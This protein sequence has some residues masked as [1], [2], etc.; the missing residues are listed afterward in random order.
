[1]K[2]FLKTARKAAVLAAFGIFVSC[3]DGIDDMIDNYNDLF[4]KPTAEETKD[5]RIPGPGDDDFVEEEMLG[6]YYALD[7]REKLYLAGP[8][9]AST[10]VWAIEPILTN[11]DDDYIGR[12]VEYTKYEIANSRYYT[13]TFAS[14]SIFERGKS[15][16][17]S[18]TVTDNLGKTYSDE[19]VL[20]ITA[21]Y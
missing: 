8:P 17:L 12:D 10:Y 20:T 18:L 19:A 11:A 3:S 6:L 5:D 13:M 15:Y 9:R 16:K 14:C 4:A 2:A 21:I 7:Y 1:M